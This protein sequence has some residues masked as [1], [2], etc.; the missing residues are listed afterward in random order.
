MR[1]ALAICLGFCLMFFQFASEVNAA[2]TLMTGDFAKDTIAVSSTLKETITLPKEDKGL[3]E[4]E[5]EA[6]FLISDYIS[7]YRN[8][9]Q[10]NTSTTFTTM[11]TALN[12]LSG[13]YKT[14]ANRPVPENLKE[15][16]NKELSKAE[17]LAVRDS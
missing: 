14:F 8:R 6:V 3:S 15:R 10:V 9:S 7:R 16:L 1:A 13:H 2:K 5:K 11:Q 4:T 17:K 12:A